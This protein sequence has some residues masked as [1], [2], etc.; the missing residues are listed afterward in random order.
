MNEPQFEI[1]H[2]A[3][4]GEG[5]ECPDGSVVRYAIDSTQT[6]QRLET[7]IEGAQA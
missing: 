1:Y 5:W 7:W 4:E 2:V 6:T 3:H